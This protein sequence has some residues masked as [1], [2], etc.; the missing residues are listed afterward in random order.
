[1]RTARIKEGYGTIQ[2]DVMC[3]KGLSVY[4]KAIY[5]LFV[6]YAGQ[7][8][9]CYPSITTICRNLK[10]SKPT[11]IGSIRELEQ[12]QL[13]VVERTQGKGSVYYPCYILAGEELKDAT[14]PL[15]D[16]ALEEAKEPVKPKKTIPVVDLSN[17][18]QEL[19]KHFTELNEWLDQ[20][21]PNVRKLST[22][23]TIVNLEQLLTKYRM[24]VIRRVLLQM[25]NYKTLVK[26][27]N[28]VYLTL[29]NW[30]KRESLHQPVGAKLS[31]TW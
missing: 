20:D 13:L 26:K 27:Y 22:Q 30:L 12:M 29:G 7:K 9:A 16:S 3:A 1:M 18:P 14:P 6:S 23:M 2:R 17:Y 25:E 10:L 5:S 24:D 4:A 28:S 19:V 11:V 15:I 8:S 21:L 31:T